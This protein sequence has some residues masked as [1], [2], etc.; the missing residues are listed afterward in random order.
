MKIFLVIIFSLIFLAAK[1]QNY[2]VKDIKSFGAK[3]DGKTNDQDAFEKAAGYFNQR[4]GNGK[5]IISTGIY[6][7]GRQTFTGGKKNKPAYSG[8]DVLHLNNITNFSIEGQNG[9]LIKYINGLY[10]GAF[11]SASGKVYNHGNNFFVNFTHAA[12]IGDCI[13][14]QNCSNISIVGVTMDGNSDNIKLGG[15]YGDVG[16]Q[17]PHYGIFISNSKHIQIDNIYVHHFALDGIAISNILSTSPDS[18]YITNSDFEYNGR[19]GFSWTGGNQVYVKNCKFNHTGK[20][21]ISSAPGAGID[22]ESEVG[23]ITNGFFDNCEFINNTG[24]GLLAL[25]GNSMNCTF[26][27]CVFIGSTNRAIWISKPNFIFQNCNIYGSYLQ[28]S[29]ANNSNNGTKFVQCN[30][31]DTVYNGSPTYGLYLIESW[32]EKGMS[33]DNCTFI[34]KIKKLC[35]FINPEN[36]TINDKYQF[37]NCTFNIKN[38]NLNNNDFAGVIQGATLKNCHFVFTD[39]VAAAKKYYIQGLEGKSNNDL[40]GNKVIFR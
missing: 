39:P 13:L 15:V 38:R 5:L 16:I 11:D 26:S 18:I 24:C 21:K 2:I 6:L 25:A 12:T 28:N 22:I 37:L 40:G 20:G 31:E 14:I 35:R 32:N 4:G 29:D 17:L 3:G 7:V 27:N 36:Y 19:Q 30:F 23:P 9:N 34:S 1:T 8:E 10:F 33:F